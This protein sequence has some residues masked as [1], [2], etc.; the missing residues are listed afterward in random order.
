MHPEFTERMLHDYRHE[1]DRKLELSNMRREAARQSVTAPG[2][3]DA[4]ALLRR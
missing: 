2:N 4:A 1:L 3:R